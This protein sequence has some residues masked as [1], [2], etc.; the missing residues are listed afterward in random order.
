MA[1][2][3]IDISMGQLPYYNLPGVTYLSNH[4]YMSI[5]ALYKM[6]ASAK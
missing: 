1:D 5:I 3:Y 6:G 2:K 4:L